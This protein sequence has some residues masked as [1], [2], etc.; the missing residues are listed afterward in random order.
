MKRILIVALMAIVLTGCYKDEIFEPVVEVK[1][2]LQIQ[3]AVGLKLESAFVTTEVA[4][5][6]KLETAQSVTIKIFDISNKVVSKETIG[7]KA[8]DNILKVYTSALPSSAYRIGLFDSN[9]QTIWLLFCSTAF[10][11]PGS[12]FIRFS[13]SVWFLPEIIEANR[14]AIVC[15]LVSAEMYRQGTLIFN[16]SAI[17]SVDLPTPGVPA[18]IDTSDLRNIILFASNVLKQLGSGSPPISCRPTLRTR[19]LIQAYP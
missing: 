5:N 11:Q 1:K 14:I 3:N 9:D 19:V 12:A 15:A 13:T 6:V 8:G 17:A 16:A 10:V 7:A 18:S 4:M 2:E